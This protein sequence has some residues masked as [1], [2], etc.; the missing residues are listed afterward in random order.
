MSISTKTGDDGKTSLP[1]GERIPKSDPQIHFLGTLDELNS[2][3][4]LLRAKDN[5][6]LTTES[7]YLEQIQKELLSL[8]NTP[9]A[10]AL[11]NLKT[12]ET[13]LTN[14]EQELPPLKDFILPGGTESAATAHLARTICRRAERLSPTPS[15]YLNRLSDYLF[16]VARKLNM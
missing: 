6:A 10:Q 15:P 5:P 3:I 2:A 16:L 13:H 11:Q 9:A 4:G 7:T 1:S 8:T 12:L 14:L